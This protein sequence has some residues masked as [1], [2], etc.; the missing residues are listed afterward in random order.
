[1]NENKPIW[2]RDDVEHSDYVEF[3]KTITK[4]QNEPLT[5]IHFTAEGEIE[6]KC[7]LYIPSE[8]PYDSL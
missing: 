7:L 6:F 8:A 2:L 5:Y 3:Y 1:V 4:D